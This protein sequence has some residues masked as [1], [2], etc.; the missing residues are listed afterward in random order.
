M[1]GQS[2][3]GSP[4]GVTVTGSGRDELDEP[5]RGDD[6]LDAGE[7]VAEFAVAGDADLL[8]LEGFLGPA[9]QFAL[10]VVGE[11]DGVEFVVA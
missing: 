10:A 6:A 5:L 1:E 8:R 7:V 2:Q 3:R 4:V 9:E 11:V